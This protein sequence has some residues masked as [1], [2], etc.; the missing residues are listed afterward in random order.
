MNRFSFS[1]QELAKILL[2]HLKKEKKMKWDVPYKGKIWV[3]K[4][5]E[6]IVLTIEFKK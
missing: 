5:G 2:A 4:H 1:D 6:G 3:A